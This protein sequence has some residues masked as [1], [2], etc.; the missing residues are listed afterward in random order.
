[1][2]VSK[3]IPGYLTCT[4]LFQAYPSDYFYFSRC[5]L[6]IYDAGKLRIVKWVHENGC[7][8]IDSAY[9]IAKDLKHWHIVK[10]MESHGLANTAT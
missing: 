2:L 9:S 5:N 6:T 3:D 10:W 8:W 1:M 4:A 7:P